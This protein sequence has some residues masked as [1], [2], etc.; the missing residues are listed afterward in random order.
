MTF[1]TINPIATL[2]PPVDN[3][4][5]PQPQPIADAAHMLVT[6]FAVAESTQARTV[7]IWNTAKVLTCAEFDTA[8]AEALKIAAKNDK[9]AGWV[10]PEDAKGRAKYGPTQSSLA[11]LASQC[12]QVFGACKIDP[13]CIVSIP[14]GAI[15][16]T[17]LFPNWSKA[18]ALAQKFLSDKGIDWQGNNVESVKA[19]RKTK[20]AT[21]E[22]AEVMAEVM[23][24]HPQNPGETMADYMARIA[25]HVDAA[26]AAAAEKATSVAAKKELTRLIKVYGE[27]VTDILEA[28]V[29]LHNIQADGEESPL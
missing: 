19:A 6:Q 26:Q 10:A 4:Q 25:E 14:D 2:V 24:A 11:T 12:R 28:M 3:P 20:Q 8:L 18:Y 7:A 21:T 27:G 15:V 5:Q 23:S 17:D 1:A 22:N 29:N 16:Q 13:E 9:L